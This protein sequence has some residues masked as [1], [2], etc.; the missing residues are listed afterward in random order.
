[1]AALTRVVARI[2]AVVVEPKR[3]PLKTAMTHGCIVSI[4]A[5]ELAYTRWTTSPRMFGA[6]DGGG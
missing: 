6:T 1:M 5:A 3:T 4:M 2:L